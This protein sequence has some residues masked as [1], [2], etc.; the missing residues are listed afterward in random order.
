[1]KSEHLA[2]ARKIET[3][4]VIIGT[5]INAIVSIAFI[6]FALLFS[7]GSR[8][9]RWG[10]QDDLYLFS[11]NINSS[12]S[13]TL[14]SISIFMLSFADIIAMDYLATFFQT[15]IYMSDSII[16]RDVW[17]KENRFW[18]GLL[19]QIKFMSTNLRFIFTVNILTAQIDIA[20]ISWLS[21]EIASAI[22]LYIK[23]T[24]ERKWPKEKE[25]IA[26]PLEMENLLTKV[27]R[28]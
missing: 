7:G 28:F 14:L 10:P 9:N 16:P 15:Y 20:L 1:M 27:I 24:D 22:I 8:F 18:L 17:K 13:Y 4:R 25:E 19:S 23:I 11:W 26:I 6:L 21:K 12:L 2:D 5:I 3:R